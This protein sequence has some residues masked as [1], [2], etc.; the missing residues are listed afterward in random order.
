[1]II[2]VISINTAI[3][4]NLIIDNLENIQS[5]E[6]K[7]EFCENTSTKWCFVTDKVMGGIS[8]GILKIGMSEKI[9]F[10]NMTGNVSTKNNGGFIQ[11]RTKVKNHPKNILYKGVRIKV[12]GNDQEYAIHI[13]TKYLFLPWQ[14]YESVFIASRE[15]NIIEL[16]FKSFKKSNFY[17]PTNVASSDIKTIGIV[18]IGRDFVA[19]VDLAQIE[20]Y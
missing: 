17:Q 6:Y 4:E 11:F 5:N 7:E 12:R 1:M 3:S 14:Y 20:F 15:W 2:N 16:P 9:K 10:Y 13:R 18:A 19:D 8:N